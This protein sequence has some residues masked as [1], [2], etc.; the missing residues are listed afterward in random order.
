MSKAQ[1]LE[2]N[3]EIDK[4]DIIAEMASHPRAV[5]LQRAKK[6]L[7]EIDSA[8]LDEEYFSVQFADRIDDLAP[9]AVPAFYGFLKHTLKARLS[10][11][12]KS[13]QLNLQEL[14]DSLYLDQYNWW[15]RWQQRHLEEV[16]ALEFRNYCEWRL[17]CMEY[18][19]KPATSAEA[20]ALRFHLKWI[21]FSI[22]QNKR[23]YQ[24][25]LAMGGGES[26]TTTDE[27]PG[28]IGLKDVIILLDELI[29]LDQAIND[30]SRNQLASF[31]AALTGFKA[32]SARTY[33][34][35]RHGLRTKDRLERVSDWLS[36]I[37]P[38]DK[39]TRKE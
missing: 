6:V 21:N 14:I 30:A 15:I 31:I 23:D 8:E 11:L 39:L 27:E 13:D 38:H 35:N 32:S 5:A 29:D 18:I 26:D 7:E 36:L 25:R 10:R 24:D 4:E 34:S 16:G 22:E 19:S 20:A 12:Q 28:R 17:N 3:N 33:L 2:P 37:R 1:P 9:D